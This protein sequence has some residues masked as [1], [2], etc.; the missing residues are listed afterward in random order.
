MGDWKLHHYF[1]DGGLELYN[2]REDIG[3]KNNLATT[4]REK[5][6]AL[7]KRLE[8]WRRHVNAPVPTEANPAFDAKAEAAAIKQALKRLK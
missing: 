5:A 2:L 8:A 3:E 4:D 6:H 7:L 1:E